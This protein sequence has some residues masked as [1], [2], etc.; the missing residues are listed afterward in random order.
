MNAQGSLYSRLFQILKGNGFQRGGVDYN[1]YV[2]NTSECRMILLVYVDNRLFWSS[3]YAFCWEF[4]DSMK[5]EFE[6][7]M[8]GEH[9]MSQVFFSEWIIQIEH[10]RIFIRGFVLQLGKS[11]S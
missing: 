5:S 9:V 3:N 1:L 11:R 6:M 7:L 4:T 2:G 8:I 10:T